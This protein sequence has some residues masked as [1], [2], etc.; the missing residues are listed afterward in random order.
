M[1][2]KSMMYQAINPR[3]RAF[4]QSLVEKSKAK[5]LVCRAENILFIN[6]K[7]AKQVFNAFLTDTWRRK[8]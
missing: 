2:Y 3:T 4:L 7:Y 1:P 5:A 6:N 8:G